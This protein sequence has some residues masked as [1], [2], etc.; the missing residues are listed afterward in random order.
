MAAESA[1]KQA[2]VVAAA[3][4]AG[5]GGTPVAGGNEFQG[6]RL[7]RAHAA[8]SQTQALGALGHFDHGA[9]Q[10]ALLAP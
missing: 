1:L 2:L 10:V 9:D 4:L 5:G 8:S 3:G 6:L 7:G